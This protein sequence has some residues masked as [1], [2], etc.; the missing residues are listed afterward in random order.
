MKMRHKRRRVAKGIY[1]NLDKNGNVTSTTTKS[2][3]GK[4]KS[5]ITRYTSGRMVR[6]VDTGGPSV[7]IYDS[8][9]GSRRR[10]RTAWEDA[11]LSMIGNLLHVG[12]KTISGAIGRQIGKL[13]ARRQQRP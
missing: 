7:S 8:R 2:G 1:Q 10:G 3:S 13:L 9:E 12:F 4:I 5:S 6:T 11:I